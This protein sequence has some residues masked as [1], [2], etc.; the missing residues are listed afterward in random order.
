MTIHEDEEQVALSRPRRRRLGGLLPVAGFAL[1]GVVVFTVV[2][3]ALIQ[4]GGFFTSPAGFR[5]GECTPG[6]LTD[7]ARNGEYGFQTSGVIDRQNEFLVVS[8]RGARPGDRIEARLHQLDG[9][10]RTALMSDPAEIRDGAN[11]IV[12]RVPVY[13]PAGEGC[14]RVDVSDARGTASYVV[15][16]REP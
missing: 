11:D 16:V 6:A 13:K 8:R 7:S 14:W 15:Q 1:A 10:G 2:T 9:A 3:Y 4:S 12:F 5:N